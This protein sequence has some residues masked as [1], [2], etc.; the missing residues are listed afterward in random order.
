V[1]SRHA[2]EPRYPVT[3]SAVEVVE[4]AA[5][6]LTPNPGGLLPRRNMD[7]RVRIAVSEAQGLLQHVPDLPVL[8][9]P[10]AVDHVCEPVEGLARLLLDIRALRLQRLST[11]I[12]ALP[13]IRL[14]CSH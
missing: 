6:S 12:E 11:P 2:T 13:T 14:N 9:Q 1:A 3:G 4:G 10:A 8:R 5:Y 7:K